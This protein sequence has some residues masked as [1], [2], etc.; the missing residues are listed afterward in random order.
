MSFTNLTA[1]R[2]GWNLYF[3]CV[4]DLWMQQDGAQLAAKW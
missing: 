2:M 4:G 3:S 1:D